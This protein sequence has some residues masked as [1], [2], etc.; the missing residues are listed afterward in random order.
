MTASKTFLSATA[1]GLL[2]EYAAFDNTGSVLKT[3]TKVVSNTDT[4]MTALAVADLNK[5]G[6]MELVASVGSSFSGDKRG[7]AVFNVSSGAELGFSDTGGPPFGVSIGDVTGDNKLEIVRGNGSPANGRTGTDGSTDGGSYVWTLNATAG[8]VWRQGPYNSFGFYDSYAMMSDLD[9]D[10]HLDIIATPTSHGWNPFDGTV[11]RVMLLNPSDGSA[12]AGYNR[13][14]GAPVQV[15]GVAD[16]NPGGNKEILVL[17]EDRTTHHYFIDALNST[18][19]LTTWK[20]YDAGS[21]SATICAINDVNGDG[22]P[23]VIVAAGNKLVVL[24]ND[25]TELWHWTATDG[26]SVTN[27]IVSDLNGD[28]LN[29]IVVFHGSVTSVLQAEPAYL[30]FREGG[31]DEASSKA[32]RFSNYIPGWDHS[33]LLLDNTVYESH[34]PQ[35]G[36]WWDPDSQQYVTLVYDNGVQEQHTLGS[37][38]YDTPKSEPPS[39]VANAEVAI[40]PSLA[41]DM[42][43]HIN[44]VLDSNFRYLG[45]TLAEEIKNL[46]PNLQKGDVYNQFTCVGLME[47]AAEQ[48]GLNGGQGFIPNWMESIDGI[49]LLSPE[50]LY[51]AATLGPA[52]A[53]ATDIL[54][55]L[56]DPVDFIITD[57]LGRRLGYAPSIGE[58]NEIPGAF[59]TG[60]APGELFLIPDRVPGEYQLT[61]YGKGESYQ[62]VFGASHEDSTIETWSFAGQLAAGA[63]LQTELNVAAGDDAYV[64]EVDTALSVLGPGVLTN[65]AALSGNALSASL[66]D[67]PKHGVLVFNSDGSF[68]YNP[69]AGFAGVDAFTYRASDDVDDSN[70]ATVMISVGYHDSFIVDS[71]TGNPSGFVAQL[72]RLVD[73]TALN[74]YDT[75]SGTFGPSDVT[76]VGQHS[77]PIPGSIVVAGGQVRFVATGGPLQSDT[78]TV[79]LQSGEDAFKDLFYGELL[80]GNADGASGDDYV[81]TFTVAAPQTIV[82]SLPDFARGPGQAVDVPAGHNGLPIQDGLP[83]RLSNAAG[84]ES[85]ELVIRY[86]P[87][88]LTISG[89]DLGADAPANSQVMLSTA[90][91]GY[92]IVSFFSPIPMWDDP[93]D[94]IAL[95]AYVSAGAAYGGVGVLDIVEVRV[96]EGGLAATADDAVEVVAFVGDATGDGGTFLAG[97]GGSLFGPYSSLDAQRIFRVSQHLDSGFEAY[98]NVD[99]MIIGDVTGDGTLSPLDC[100]HIMAESLGYTEGRLGGPVVHDSEYIPPLPVMANAQ[101]VANVQSVTTAEDGPLAITLTGDD[102]D[103]EVVQTLT[104][105]IATNPSHGELSG[106][107]PATGAVTYTPNPDFNG[108]DSFTFTVADDDKAGPTANLTSDPAAVTITITP[109][110]ER[111]TASTQTVTAAEDASQAITLTGEDGDPMPSEVQALT[112]AI[113]SQ[114]LHGTLTGFNMNTGAVT[115][116]PASDYFGADSFKFRVIDDNTAGHPYGLM[117]DEATVSISVAP[118]N[119]A[120]TLNRISDPVAIDEDAGLQTVNLSG[121]GP[122]DGP[123]ELGQVLTVTAT[124]SNTALIPNPTVIYTSPNATGSLSYTPVGNANGTAIIT[125]TVTDDGGT[126]NGGVNTF[127]RTFTVTVNEVNDTPVLL[128]GTVSNLTVAEDSGT[129]ALFAT[130]LVFGPGGG[131]DEAGQSLTYKVT[132]VPSPTLGNIVLADGT[133]V[134]TVDTEYTLSQINGMQFKT[135]QDANGGPVMFTFTVT[136]NG[137]TNGAADAK[138]LTESLTITITEVNDTPVLLSGTVSNLTAAEDS[139]TAQLFTTPLVFGPGGGSDEAGQTLT[140]KVTAVPS[141]TLGNIVLADATTVVTVDTEYTLLQINGMQFTTVHD[142][143]GGPATFTFTVMDNGTTNGAADAKTLTE[144]LTITITEVNDTPVLLSGTVSNLTVAEDS[145]TTALFATPLVFGPGGGSDEAGQSLTYKVTA[146]PSPT[147]GNIV[148]TDGTTVVTADTEYTLS[149]INGIQFKTVQDANGGPVTFTFTVTDNGTTNGTADAKTLTESLTITVTSV[150][151]TPVLLSGTVSNLT[152]AEDSGTTP[153]FATPLVFG[154]GG[155]SDEAGQMLTYKVTAVPSSTL[156]NIILADGTTVVTVDTEYTL[157]QINGMQFTTVHDANGGPVTFAFTVTD[158]GTTNGA[159]DAKTLTESLTITVTS[160]NDT[161]VLL[162]GTVSN[163]T[164]AEDW[165]RTLCLPLR[166]CLVPVAARMKPVKR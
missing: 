42:V 130:P 45:N 134:V 64:T 94:I 160:V 164:V 97:G 60:D 120:P 55:G 106:F 151:D 50:L 17:R 7:V 61:L 19:G 59:Y 48:S 47:W 52:I 25:L 63:I 87:D 34:P 111:P 74:L 75:Q 32:G 95:N 3:Y 110:N 1:W 133:T 28:G 86:D 91:P 157:L 154:P 76:V 40:S 142:A 62:A 136:D 161:P 27:A 119:D 150:N 80:D 88:L 57:P 70:L 77:G 4:G 89:A 118:V 49:P 113:T 165:G 22:S 163:L 84:V 30:L 144:S 145:G 68:I 103:P 37:F 121:I 24:K 117:S 153:L 73:T 65:D 147:L 129:T 85:L 109:V 137:T 15:E 81:G 125:V 96:N 132:A 6:T 12:R 83:I 51:W 101:P 58:V 53:D 16:L 102:G 9:N 23:E 116:T 146:V 69:N 13:D 123:G 158:N 18:S 41:Q 82:V 140:Y 26:Q 139:G 143:N 98:P 66:V 67:A 138:T 31:P 93:A 122:G 11:G 44:T 21:A 39:Q 127:I 43:S 124:S 8:Q 35:A 5:D 152:V 2:S 20:S 107:V 56:L 126:D 148:L 78:Y 72:N 135:V 105:T 141:P 92:A 100:S 166:W 54:V 156:G 10:G 36:E 14:F 90:V 115:Y 155:G 131:S 38:R 162:S 29:E 112:F 33:A 128:S 79:T 46:K 71:L 104:Y 114:P 108:T 99:P 149:Q 159:A